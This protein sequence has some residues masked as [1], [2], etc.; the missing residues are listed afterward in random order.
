M[1]R[2]SSAIDSE[3]TASG[4][5]ALYAK[6]SEN[7]EW[8]TGTPDSVDRRIAQCK[9]IANV[10]KAASVRLAGRNAGIQYIALAQEMD[11]DRAALEG[12]RRDLLTAASDREASKSL[13]ELF[14][15]RT[16]DDDFDR[17]K[18]MY[19][20][21]GSTW[22][23]Y[24]ERHPRKH[25]A[26]RY[27]ADVATPQP[28][29]VNDGSGPPMESP[30][31]PPA[32]VMPPTPQPTVMASLRPE[33]RFF[34]AEQECDDLGE[35]LIRAQ[36]HAER[37][38]STLPARQSRTHVASFVEAVRHEAGD[39]VIPRQ[40]RQEEHELAQRF[41]GGRE[42]HPSD[43][44]EDC[45]ACYSKHKMSA[46]TASLNDFPADLMYLE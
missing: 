43:Y 36:W 23:E 19:A 2:E 11:S 35:L 9:R 24:D 15:P 38:T 5:R 42:D 3:R 17:S 31:A 18:N 41:G 37:V 34:I 20:P 26:G 25:E 4:V 33:A 7:E 13:Y 8:F 1:F 12:L 21:D 30:L 40:S 44:W 39:G 32:P 10:A 27:A 29:P 46:R 16:M 45:S 28:T 6:Y 14:P 22:D